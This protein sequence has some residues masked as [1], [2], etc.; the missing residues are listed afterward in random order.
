[1]RNRCAIGTHRC[2]IAAQSLRNQYAI[3]TQSLRNLY[4]SD[5]ESDKCSVN[6]ARMQHGRRANAEQIQRQAE[7]SQKEI[8]ARQKRYCRRARG[9]SGSKTR[10]P[11]SRVRMRLTAQSLCNRCAI[12]AKS[13]HNL[14]V[15]VR[16]RT[17]A[18]IIL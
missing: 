15:I 18:A 1:M 13:I 3:G 5:V 4:V 8:T 10:E 17:Y 2:A 12:T 6:A 11:D 14:S 16:N 9:R 7:Q